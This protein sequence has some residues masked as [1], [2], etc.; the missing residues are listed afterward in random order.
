MATVSTA[1]RTTSGPGPVHRRRGPTHPRRVRGPGAAGNGAEPPEEARG[2]GKRRW[3]SWR[4][5][6]PVRA[7]RGHAEP[8]A[9]GTGNSKTGEHVG[10]QFAATRHRPVRRGARR[11]GRGDRHGRDRGVRG[12]ER[13]RTRP[14]LLQAHREHLDAREVFEVA[15]D[16]ARRLPAPARRPPVLTGSRSCTSP[17]RGC[18][19]LWFPAPTWTLGRSDGG[20]SYRWRTF[21]RRSCW[22]RP[23]PWTWTS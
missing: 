22:S 21:T 3:R 4:A 2:V 8:A 15:S 10:Q 7:G 13:R 14:P 1:S 16:D 20:N 18:P 12:L 11:P 9:A 5:R 19:G 17:P 6:A 23:P